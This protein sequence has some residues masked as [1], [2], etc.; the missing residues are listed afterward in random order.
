MPL[1][2]SVSYVYL[3]FSCSSAVFFGLAY[4]AV[5]KGKYTKFLFIPLAIASLCMIFVLADTIVLIS[6]LEETVKFLTLSSVFK[7]KLGGGAIAG[8][9]FA[10]LTVVPL[11]LAKGVGKTP[12][13]RTA[14]AEPVAER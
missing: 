4:F 14:K 10:A 9:V 7:V 3:L 8:L 5:M 1:H 11:C 2:E 6:G 13:G 12:R